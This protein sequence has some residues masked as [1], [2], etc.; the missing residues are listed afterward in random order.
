MLAVR[1]ILL[2]SITLLLGACATQQPQVGSDRVEMEVNSEA[3]PAISVDYSPDGKSLITGGLDGITRRWDLTGAS[4]TM[5]L[6]EASGFIRDVSYLPDGKSI[7]VATNNGA[8]FWNA[9]T[10]AQIRQLTGGFGGKL[11]F[12]PDGKYVLGGA[13]FPL[14]LEN[15]RTRLLD[16]QSGKI[17]WEFKGASG[18]ISPNGKYIAVE[19]IENK[20]NFVFPKYE[21]FISLW[22][23]ETGEQLWKKVERSSAFTFSPDSQQLL[24]A[25]VDFD[26]RDLAI[27]F[28][29]FDTVAGSKL[30]EFG[31]AKIQNDGGFSVKHLSRKVKTLTYSADGKYFLSGD[32]VGS[33]RLWDAATGTMVRQF[34]SEDESIDTLMYAAPAIKFSPDA[35]TAAIVS[36][37]STKLFDVSTGNEL[38][39]MISFAGGE[40]LATTPGGYY[41]S[42]EKGDQHLNVTV[43]GKPYTIAQ[44]RESFYRPDIVKVALLGYPLKEPRNAA[45]VKAPP[46]V[47]IINTPASVAAEQATVSL[48]VKDQGGGIGDVRLYLNGT[49][50]VQDQVSS[51]ASS[52]RGRAADRN[53]TFSYPLQL[54]SGKN[55]LRAVAF[56]ADNSMQSSDALY[57]IDAKTVQKKPVLHALV[58]GIQDYANPKLTLKYP[59]ADAKLFA[60][61]LYDPPT[62][63]YD[64]SAEL[65]DTVTITSLTTR[66]ETTRASIT[67]ALNTMRTEAG[68]EDM[69]VF[70]VASQGMVDNGEYFFLTSNVGDTSSEKLKSDALSLSDLRELFANIPATQ[71]LIVFDTCN[72]GKVDDV[73]QMATLTHGMG[74]YTAFKILSRAIG[75]TILA[76]SNSPQEERDGYLDHGLFTYVLSNGLQG[77]A[78]PDKDGLVKT[79]KL[80]S[81]IGNELPYLDE[82]MFNRRQYPFSSLS[83]P[84]FPVV[85]LK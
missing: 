41:N 15:A 55:S 45:D 73:V 12:S 31:Q 66:Q 60:A 77:K 11:T 50:V 6:K 10:G 38:V 28:K 14:G 48:E 79:T 69:F 42:S 4:E 8:T 56:N 57:E 2:L 70:Y 81:Y 20:G 32:Q 23:T 74:E 54:V 18:K 40:W 30:K 72:A 51:R 34:N 47:S 16:V 29:L 36:L 26:G 9:A 3:P 39:T 37:G 21:F 53:R 17:L 64:R 33:Y 24:V 49:A 65:F 25:H 78:D 61:A 27:S 85:R 19:G 52:L 7:A 80:A 22:D 63:F 44:L 46:L 5:E 75:S 13:R 58:V 62:G 82:Q 68:A 35:K 76:I 59:V 83:G 71:K 43:G 67:A 1:I 84:I